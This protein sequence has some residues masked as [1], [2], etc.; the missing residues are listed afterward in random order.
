LLGADQSSANV[1]EG[2][3]FA[4]LAALRLGWRAAT[5]R[6]KLPAR[7]TAKLVMK[8]QSWRACAAIYGSKLLQFR[9]D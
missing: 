9:V 8:A 2:E 6:G 3:L 5:K 7:Q 4:L 1:I